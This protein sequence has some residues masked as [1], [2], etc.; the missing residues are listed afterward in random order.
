M[1]VLAGLRVLDLSSGPVGGLTTM[2]MADFG[3]EVVKIEAPA[4]D[5][6]RALP[7]APFWLRGKRSAVLDLKT[8]A[9]RS[10]LLRIVRSADVLVVSGPPERARTLGADWDTL[11]AAKPDLVHC[12]ITG[13]GAHG[14]YAGLPGYEGLVA[15]LSGRMQGFAGQAPREGPVY[16]ALPVASHATSQGALQGIL[17]ALLARERGG[18]GQRVETSLLRGLLPYDLVQLLTLQLARRQS[19]P[20]PDPRAVGGGMPTLNYHPVMTADGRWIQLG[21][22]LEHLLYA[23]LDATGLLPGLLA[24]ERFQKSPAEWSPE[25]IEVARD[26]ILTR[27]RERSADEWMEIFRAN[28]NIVAEPFLT[29]QEALEHPDLVGNGDVVARVDPELGPMLQLGVIARLSATP[30]TPGGAAPRLGEHSAE[31]LADRPAIAG[32][33][34]IA[35]QAEPPSSGRP[36]EGVTILE[37]ATI[38]ATPLATTML[39][40]LGARVIKVEALEGDPYRHLLPRGILAVKTNAGKQS[41]CL[42]LKTEEGRRLLN[43]L[44]ARADVLVHNFRP[45]V[46]ERLGLGEAEMRAQHSALIYVAVTGYGP[47]AP[48]AGRPCTHPVAGASMG[49]V[50]FQAGAGMPPVHCASLDELR[51]AASRLMRANESNPDPNTSVVVASA[52]LL[53]LWA[54]ERSGVAQ[55]VSVNMLAAN[56]YANADDMIRYGGKPERPTVAADLHGLSACYRLYRTK[57]GWV[58]LAIT[59]AREWASFAS[60]VGSHRVFSDARF[61]TVELRREHDDALSG[62]LEELFAEREAA[63]WQELLVGHGV[64]C[65]RADGSVGEFLL[66]DAH[67]RDER[68]APQV[69]HR[70][71]GRTHRWGPLVVCNGGPETLLPGALAG[72]HTDAL[73]RELGRNDA[74]I[75]RLRA[76]QVVASEPV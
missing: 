60:A 32:A 38:I 15:A 30:G 67:A 8:Q 40:D 43:E 35:A 45:G 44:A 48:G 47:G 52:I 39:A 50:C 61:P 46:P 17:A 5:R 73:L 7:S 64:G 42:D 69:Q 68:L 37:V 72:D 29:A 1:T 59:N 53:A 16:S 41:I 3:A 13:W 57:D 55:T 14:A 63:A 58:F 54:R 26:R 33:K 21:N 49:G 9:G 31:E 76:Q 10:E 75:A 71:F 11:V 28:G 24:D 66:D 36:L 65:V 12:S 20:V 51:D 2:V 22:L 23:F 6:F 27:M 62:A 19:G 4:G 18:G 70:R 34:S 56:A 74:Q 25:A